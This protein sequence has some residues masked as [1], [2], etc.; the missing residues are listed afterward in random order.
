MEKIEAEN[1]SQISYEEA[2]KKYGDGRYQACIFG[3][4]N[5]ISIYVDKLW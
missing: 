1:K 3:E 4:F 2:V 5:W